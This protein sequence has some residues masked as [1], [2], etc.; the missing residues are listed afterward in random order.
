MKT[1]AKDVMRSDVISVTTEATLK[2]AV[3][4]LSGHKISAL[5]IV[6]TNQ[7]LVGILSETDIIEYSS[8]LHVIPMLSTYG[9][10]SPYENVKEI[11]DYKQGFDLLEKT[12]VK[13]LM[14]QKVVTVQLETSAL[15]VAKIMN[16]KKINHVPV[17][18]KDGKLCGIIARADM[19]N[20]IASLNA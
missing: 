5:P 10:I 17:I 8:K 13:K 15:E 9:W 12:T 7:K 4:I 14:S 18:D 19:I 3:R 6:D 2:E 20:S 11:F 16:K 1:T